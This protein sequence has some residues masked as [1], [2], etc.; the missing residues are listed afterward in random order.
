MKERLKR[1][2][3]VI[4]RRWLSAFRLVVAAS[5][6]LGADLTR[7][8]TPVAAQ[9]PGKPDLALGAYDI[10]ALGYDVHE[11]SVSGTARSFGLSGEAGSDGNWRAV[12]AG[13]APYKTRIVVVSPADASKFN[14]TVVV[15]WLNVTGGLDVPVDWMTVHRELMR[16]GYAYVAVSAQK[17][18]IEGGSNL[19]R[20]TARPLKTA[21][22]ERYGDLSH[23]GDAFAFD[24]YSDVAR[25]LRGKQSGTLLGKLRPRRLIG[26][27]ESQSAFFMATYV[28]AVDPLAKLYDGFLVHSRSGIAAPLDGTSLLGAPRESLQQAIK[29]RNDLRVPVMQVITETD[30]IELVNSIGFH[31]ARQP[32]TT[33]LRVWEIAGTAHADNYLF[34]VGSIDS[35]LLPIEK[36]AAAWA[37][38][39]NLQ[40]MKLP[41]PMNNAPQHHYVTQAALWHL[42][43]WLRT[44]EAPPHAQPLQLAPGNPPTLVL[45]EHGNARG[46]VRTPWVDVPTSRLSGLGAVQSMLIGT[47]EPF[48]AATLNRLFPQG[49]DEY[50]QRFQ[51]SLDQAIEAGFILAADRKEIVDLATF[52]YPDSAVQTSV[53]S[54]DDAMKMLLPMMSYAVI[55]NI[56]YRTVGGWEGKLDVMTPRGLKG[57]NATLIYYHGGGWKTGSKEERMPLLLPYMQMGWTIVNVEYRLSDVALA[58]AAVEDARCALRWVYQHATQTVQTSSGPVALNIDLKKLVTSGTSAGGHLALVVG[59]APVSAGLDATCLSDRP[60]EMKVAA[61]VD[62]FGIS[63]VDNLLDIPEARPLAMGWLGDNPTRQLAKRVSPITYVSKDSPPIISIHGDADPGVPYAQKLRFHQELDRAGTPHELVTIK[64]GGHGIFTNAE[65]LRAYAAIRVFLSKHVGPPQNEP[66]GE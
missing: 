51:A 49:K 43:R 64:G 22:P 41:R 5:A 58:P 26:I 45:D 21:N 44:G 12:A 6:L 2:G 56:T 1:T 52:S 14:G 31:A 65:Y 59:M 46:G 8:E 63:D 25:L 30:L 10:A 48:D 11:F 38:L 50:L 36:L 17:V 35:G 23:P 39:D 42:D 15:E 9:L 54:D 24:I 27:G 20:G 37:P 13:S 33:R 47:T 19:G 53:R 55:P 29:L 7:A 4:A 16:S 61:I 34:G 66:T 60:G 28:N 3:S 57:P 18:G 62:W 32:D 40:G